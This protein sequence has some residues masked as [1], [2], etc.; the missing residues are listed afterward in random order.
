MPDDPRL[1]VLIDRYQ[2]LMDAGRTADLTDLCRDCPELRIDLE[3]R[4]TRIRK[5]GELLGEPALPATAHVEVEVDAEL[6]LSDD[7]TGSVTG[8]VFRARRDSPRDTRFRPR[9]KAGWVSCTGAQIGLTG[10]SP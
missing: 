9:A 10:W 7:K 4:V 5:V 6:S 3:K 1:D 2:D 8:P